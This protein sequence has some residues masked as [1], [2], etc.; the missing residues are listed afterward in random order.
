MEAFMNNVAVKIL[1]EPTSNKGYFIA[2]SKEFCSPE[3]MQVITRLKIQINFIA[4][5]VY[6]VINIM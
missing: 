3:T 4:K 2:I 1:L 6:Y 5:K